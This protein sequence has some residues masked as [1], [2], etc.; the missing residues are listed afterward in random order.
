MSDD[1]GD[2]NISD[3][4]GDEGR[5]NDGRASAVGKEGGEQRPTEG[6][7]DMAVRVLHCAHARWLRRGNLRRMLE[8]GEQDVI[9]T[10]EE[11]MSVMRGRVRQRGEHRVC[12]EAVPYKSMKGYR[13]YPFVVL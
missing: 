4:G 2:D 11:K 12:V 13:W 1:D 3:S 6:G 9:V 10:S 5:T 7:K 8:R